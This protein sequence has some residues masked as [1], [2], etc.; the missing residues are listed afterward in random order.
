MDQPKEDAAVAEIGSEISPPSA[1]RVKRCVQSKLTWHKPRV[2]EAKV[3]EVEEE[4]EK[5][6]EVEGEGTKKGTSR[7]KTPKKVGFFSVLGGFDG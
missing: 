1:K 7:A 5:F 6:E 4:K 3:V 2:E